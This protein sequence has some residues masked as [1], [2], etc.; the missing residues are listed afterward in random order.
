[1]HSARDLGKCGS[2]G[3]ELSGIFGLF[4]KLWMQSVATFDHLAA[5]HFGG[6]ALLELLDRWTVLFHDGGL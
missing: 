4:A 3:S 2:H 5:R 6:I 1:M